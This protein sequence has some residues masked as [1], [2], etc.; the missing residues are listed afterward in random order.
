MT[1]APVLVLRHVAH[2]PLGSLE[3]VFA[4]EGVEF[5]YVDLFEDVPEGL[6]LDEIAGLVVLGGPMNANETAAYPFLDRELGWIRAAVA[7]QTP[8]LG[9]CLGAQLMAKALGGRVTANP[10][11][12]IGWYDLELLPKAA[13][14]RLLGGCGPRET[15]FEWHGDTFTLPEGAVLLASTPQCG[16]QV[17]RVGPAAWG[18]QFHVEMTGSL[19]EQWLDRPGFAVEAAKLGTIDPAAIRRAIPDRLPAM[20]AFTHEVLRRF[21]RLCR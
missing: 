21:A 3:Q 20:Q 2:V 5:T 7:R 16:N 18:L 10:V 1:H 19:I 8:L 6:P 9:I 11:K 13:G 14:D 12:E 17:F 4:E 15:V